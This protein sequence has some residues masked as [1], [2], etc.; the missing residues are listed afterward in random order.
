MLIILYINTISLRSRKQDHE[1]VLIFRLFINN[2][3]QSVYTKTQQ[4][5]HYF[6]L[7][8]IS[9]KNLRNPNI[10]ES[11]DLTYVDENFNQLFDVILNNSITVNQSY[12][13]L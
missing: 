7:F 5:E 3:T 12:I 10:T 8:K 13:H 11:I 1:E 6:K 4:E 2:D 9:L